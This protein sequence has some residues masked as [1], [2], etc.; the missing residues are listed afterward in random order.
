MEATKLC[1]PRAEAGNRARI[2]AEELDTSPYESS[3]G[4][5]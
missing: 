5:T 3:R 2:R 1:I 4:D